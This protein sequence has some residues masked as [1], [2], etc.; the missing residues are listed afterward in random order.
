M[1]FIGWIVLGLIVGVIV[2]AVMPGKGGGGW[3]TSLGLGVLG[4]IVGGF[5]DDLLFDDG[6][7]GVG[8]LGSWLLTIGGG[9]IVAGT[10]GAVTG[11]SKTTA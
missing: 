2:S 5:T 6:K 4:G 7:M 3:F 11:R 1:G 9:F 8:N 10:Y